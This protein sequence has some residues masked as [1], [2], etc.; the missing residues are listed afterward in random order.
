MGIDQGRLTLQF[1]VNRD[2]TITKVVV[3]ESS[4][5]ELLDRAGVAA[6][7]QGN[8]LPKLPAGFK[9]DQIVLKATFVY[10]PEKPRQ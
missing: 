5:R 3:A 9:S 8:P 6:I 1:A 4:G 10:Q 7:A 2:G